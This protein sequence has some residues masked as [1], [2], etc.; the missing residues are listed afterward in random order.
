MKKILAVCVLL[1]ALAAAAGAQSKFF[2]GAKLGGETGINKLDEEQE[3]AF[4]YA[5]FPTPYTIESTFAFTTGIYGGY[6]FTKKFALVVELDLFINQG[7]KTKALGYKSYT[8]TYNS[9]DFPI[10][11]RYEFLNRSFVLG[12]EAGPYLS[13][14]FGIKESNGVKTMK[15]DSAGMVIGIGGGLFAAYPLGPGRITGDFRV[16]VDF[17]AIKEET[18][19]GAVELFK[20][21]GF[22]LTVG[23]EISLGK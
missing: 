16:L 22:V 14:P 17:S 3:A 20:R 9:I 12:I 18:P 11:V 21:R 4:D 23:Y 13:I 6:S 19:I 15:F 8:M 2:L 7:M 1:T 10:L 5:F